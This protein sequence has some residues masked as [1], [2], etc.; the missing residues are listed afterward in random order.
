[1]SANADRP[2]LIDRRFYE[3]PL[4]RRVGLMLVQQ[5]EHRV[6]TM[7][8][9][10]EVRAAAAGSVH[11][12]VLATLADVTCASALSDAFDPLVE[13]PV[14]TDMHVRHYRQPRSGPLRAGA[15]LVHRGRRPSSAECA[16]ADA[17]ERVLVRA[18]ATHMMVPLNVAYGS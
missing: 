18:T 2:D 5:G 16:V 1:V 12:G 9:S 6:V 14:T 7:E 13:M 15:R 8:L 4:H 17:D 10:E 11:G 3:V